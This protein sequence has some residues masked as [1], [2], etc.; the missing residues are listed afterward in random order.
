MKWRERRADVG[1]FRISNEERIRLGLKKKPR[2]A[3]TLKIVYP[4]HV[5]GRAMYYQTTMIA[6][7]EL[8]GY[9]QKYPNLEIMGTDNEG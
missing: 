4:V 1:V 2:G 5:D 3:L 6:Q 9:L 8:E 7:D